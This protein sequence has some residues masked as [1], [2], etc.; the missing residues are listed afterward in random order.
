MKPAHSAIYSPNLFIMKC[1]AEIY[2]IVREVRENALN[3]MKG[4]G[5]K[6]LRFLPTREEYEKM[7]EK[8]QDYDE[9]YYENS[10]MVS[11][12]DK[13]DY[14]IGYYVDY[15]STDDFERFSIHCSSDEYGKE[16]FGEYDVTWESFVSLLE[17]IE[18]TLNL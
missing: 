11:Y 16:V 17:A 1:I 18:N 10:P 15:I 3:S 7:P 8:E 13:Y 9:Y 12:V 6:E 2:E 4:K 14:L 5:L